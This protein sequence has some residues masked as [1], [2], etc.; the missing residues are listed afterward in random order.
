MKITSISQGK[1]NQER[2]N[3]YID[4]AYRLSVD[5]EV[6]ARFQ[7]LK[8]KEVTEEFLV[9]VEAADTSRQALNRSIHYLSSRIRSEKEIRQHLRKYEFSDT[10]IQ[11]VLQKL[12]EMSYVNDQ[13]F[14][15]LYTRTQIN[16]TQ[17]GPGQ[18]ERELIEKGITREDIETAL[19][20]YDKESLIENGQKL[21][22]K[23]L[24]RSRSLTGKRLASKIT[25]ELMQK[26]YPVETAKE[27][28]DKVIQEAPRDEADLLGQQFDKLL[29]KNARFEPA[30]QKQKIIQSL[31][32]K[33]FSYDT[34]SSYIS[35]HEIRF[36]GE[37]E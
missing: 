25:T 7:L 9:E 26:G 29:R 22:Q 32:Q 15:L 3:L 1:R 12:S 34:I 36:G 24:R 4:G 2:Y 28:A 33:G 21:A 23:I 10:V 20:A 19:E 6:L 5:E 16:T 13:E 30:K 35:E 37:E 27:L 17:K 14:A 8:D 31:M 11:Q 18:I